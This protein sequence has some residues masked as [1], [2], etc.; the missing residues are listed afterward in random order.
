M[1]K[2]IHPRLA[3]ERLFTFGSGTGAAAE[4]RRVSRR[5]I[6]DFVQEDAR[7]LR[8]RL[9]GRDRLKLDEYLAAM[10]PPA[11]HK[12]MSRDERKKMHEEMQAMTT[13]QRLD[14][15]AAM[16][17]ERDA[18]MQQRSQATRNFYDLLTAEQQKVFDANTMMGG[19][20]GKRG[21]KRGHRHG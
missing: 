2:E 3:F 8:A 16:K 17:A 21:D 11:N 14:R 5:S 4:Q 12:R 19:E 10:Q 7:H 20:H 18:Q 1:G 15:M 6:L 13:P 9:G